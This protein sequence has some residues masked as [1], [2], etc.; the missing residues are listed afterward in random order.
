LAMTVSFLKGLP[1]RFRPRAG[2]SFDAVDQNRQRTDGF[3]GP[4]R[5]NQ[6]GRR[7]GKRGNVPPQHAGLP[8]AERLD[9]P[10][11]GA[12]AALKR[13][14][15]GSNRSTEE[16]QIDTGSVAARSPRWPTWVRP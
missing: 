6:Q 7:A 12:K 3:T 15:A 2:L 13:P 1:K 11:R 4:V 14:A 16:G 8:C 9:R 5:P 10:L